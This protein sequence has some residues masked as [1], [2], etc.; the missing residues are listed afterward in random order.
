MS[1]M[2]EGF[3]IIDRLKIATTSEGK[4]LDALKD[5]K[6]CSPPKTSY[7]VVR[8][9]KKLFC[10]LCFVLSACFEP[11]TALNNSSSSSDPSWVAY[12]YPTIAVRYS[13]YLAGWADTK[14]TAK[15]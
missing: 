2:E 4:R 6:V 12:K 15:F 3:K 1:R 5:K 11:V 9:H 8:H 10:V 7:W 14:K 13:P